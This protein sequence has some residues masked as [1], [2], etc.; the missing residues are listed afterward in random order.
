MK[1]IAFLGLGAMG[2]RMAAN[3]VKAGYDVRLYNRSPDK[4]APLVAQGATLWATPYAAATDAEAV[5][6]MVSDDAA[7]DRIWLDSESG[8]LRALK[9]GMIAIDSS[10][11]TP[12]WVTTLSQKLAKKGVAFLDAPVIGS[13]PQADAG[14]LIY[15][16]GGEEE[17]V[18]RSLPLLAVMGSAFHHAGP[19]G[20]G[21]T[22]KLMVNALFGIQVA[23]M[24]EILTLIRRLDMNEPA[25]LEILGGLP[26]VSPAAKNALSM[27]ADGKFAPLFPIDLVEK[28]FRYAAGLHNG[29]ND[30]ASL[31]DATA[32]LY[33]QAKRKGLG[34]KNITGILQLYE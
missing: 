34:G 13:R 3:L 32:K 5:I 28:D 30:G 7:S 31:I 25:I 18:Q 6:A 14:Q 21:A 15:L 24:A 20:A 27:M 16:M 33:Q 22:L 26:V 19:A 8:A 23:A 29:R 4:A 12:Q 2:G 9:P 17:A 11:L 1:V 10:T